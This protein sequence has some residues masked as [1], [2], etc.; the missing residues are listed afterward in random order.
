MFRQGLARLAIFLP[1]SLICSIA[2]AQSQETVYRH[3]SSDKLEAVLKELNISHQKSAG[4]KDG[5]FVYDYERKGVK[6]RLYNYSGEDLWVESDYTEKATLDL[7]NRWNMRAK[8]SRAVLVNDGKLATLSLESQ[9]DCTLGIT[10]GMMREFIRRFDG[11][12]LAFG[13]FLKK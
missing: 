3:V 7:A 13:E 8:F 1:F 5:I 6:V 11:E 10:E 4:K 12:I 2:A 9:I